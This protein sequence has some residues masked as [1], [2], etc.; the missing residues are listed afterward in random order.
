M[1][2]FYGEKFIVSHTMMY[3]VDYTMAYAPVPLD[4]G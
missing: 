2:F 4:S 1:P 3:G